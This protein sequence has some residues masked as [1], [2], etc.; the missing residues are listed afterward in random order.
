MTQ[1]AFLVGTHRFSFQA[2]K[3][4]EIVGVTFVTPEGLETRPCYQ[5]RFDDGRN[6]LVPLSES[7][8]FEIISEQDVATGK[9]PAVTH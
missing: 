6:D 8:H 4:A 1:K 7:H 9:I 2:G 5:I 3:P